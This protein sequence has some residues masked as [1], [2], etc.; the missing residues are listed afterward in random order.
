[1]A[2]MLFGLLMPGFVSAQS[3]TQGSIYGKVSSDGSAGVSGAT[4][5]V[6]S[7]ASG[8]TLST[9]TSLS[10]NYRFNALEPGFYNLLVSSNSEKATSENVSVNLGTGTA[11]NLTLSSSIFELEAVVVYGS[12]ISPVDVSSIETAHNI[13]AGDL[14]R[15]PVVRDLNA[16]IM[17]APGAVLGDSAF[18]SEAQLTRTSYNAGFGYASVGGSSVAE[19]SYYINGFNV[20]NARNGLGSSTVPFQFYDQFQIKEGGYSAEFGRSIGGAINT[21]TKSGTNEWTFGAGMYYEP[22]SL[23]GTGSDSIAPDGSYLNTGSI[24]EKDTTSYYVEVGGPI[25]KDKLFFYG[26]Y[27]ARDSEWDNFTNSELRANKDDDPFWGAKIDWNITDNHLLEL[28][29]FSDQHDAVRETFDYDRD[30]GFGYAGVGASKGDTIISRGGDNYIVNYTGHLTDNF[31]VSAMYG[32]SE[33]ALKTGAP[34]DTSCPAIYDG[35]QGALVA[36][37]CWT[38]LVPESGFDERDAYRLDM[39]WDIGDNHRLKF[40][41][42]VDEFVSQQAQTYSGT[43]LGRGG[44]YWRYYTDSTSST[45]FSARERHFEG[46]G[47]FDTNATAIYVEDEWQVNDQ[48]M[49]R[50]GFRAE[51]FE[52]FNANGEPYVTLDMEDQIAP[53]LGFS[54]DVNGDGRSKVYGSYGTYY[55]PVAANTNIRLSGAEFFTQDFYEL[56]SINADGTP[57]IGALL[58]EAVF[59]DGTVPDTSQGTDASIE[60]MTQ[61][62]YIIGYETELFDGGWVGGVRGTF[63]ELDES[64]ED[65]A[66]DAAVIARHPNAAD[67]YTGFHAYVLT[68]PGTDMTVATTP[69]ADCS[70]P[71]VTETYSAAELGYPKAEREYTALTFYMNKVWDGKWSMNASYVWSESKGN[72]EGYVRSDNGQDDAGI[73]TN[74]DQPGLTDNAIGKLPNNRD[75]QFKFYGNYQIMDNLMGGAAFTWASGRPINGFGVHPTDVF[76]QAYGSEAFFVQ[77]QAVPRGS[78]GELSSLKNLDLML[79]Y[80]MAFGQ[81]GNLTLKL[82]VFNV[83]NWDT[84]TEVDEIGD[85]DISSPG[86]PANDTYL[87]PTNFQAERS[88]RLGLYFTF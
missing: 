55:M 35:R 78:V 40:G 37:G 24:D 16:V 64:L 86:G 88:M 10:G 4:V 69:T 66:I 76:A 75:H 44:L 53:R 74:F 14:L 70:G 84:V 68:N 67:C 34:S 54:Y 28:T 81:K 45:G 11:L 26:I 27:Q 42:D 71:L 50:L 80:D 82:D 20:T 59:G 47:S 87:L 60:P 52:N 9:Q 31:T 73:T 13:T 72:N 57:V 62:E 2:V 32:T 63:R 19:N 58:E 83:F 17:T 12:E 56:I 29:G 61:I 41:Y 36:L 39:V 38:N 22:E 43:A 51:E 77:G 6:T 7:I 65:I 5:T 30:N 25:I 85:E 15:Q 18:G 79:K 23:R 21:T 1:M 33:Y 3:N 48:L 49:L 46:G 8:I